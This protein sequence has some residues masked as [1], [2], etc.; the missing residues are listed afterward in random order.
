ML[1][2]RPAEIGRFLVPGGSRRYGEDMR[3]YRRFLA[4]IGLAERR[5]RGPRLPIFVGARLELDVVTVT[6]TARNLSAG[7]VFLETNVPIAPGVRGALVRDGS[8]ER[9]PV[10]VAEIHRR[11]RRGVGL[12]FEP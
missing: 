8:D 2:R 1:P 3:L 5:A 12:S 7:G 9:I 11:G 10:R 6:G 4:R